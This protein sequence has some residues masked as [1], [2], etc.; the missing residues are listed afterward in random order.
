MFIDMHGLEENETYL[1]NSGFAIQYGR[2]AKVRNC[3][4]SLC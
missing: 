1:R 2:L 4:H 3:I